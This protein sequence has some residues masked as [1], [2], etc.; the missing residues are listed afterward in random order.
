M[1]DH[2]TVISNL[3][4]E[5]ISKYISAR[6]PKIPFYSSVKA[7]RLHKASDFGPKY[8]QDN[9]E[10][11]VLFHSAV[12]ELLIGSKECSVHLEVGPHS[13]LG[14]PLRQIYSETSV[15]INYAPTLV[16][17]KDDTVSFL[18]A[19][20]QLHSLGVPI[21][22]PLATENTQVLTDLPTY[23]WHYEKS[24]WAESRI[25]KNW[26]FRKHLPHDL[27][28]LRII[29]GSDI[30]PTWRNEL[31]LVNIPWLKD[32]CVGNDIVLPGA[33]Y[34]AMAGEAVFQI[35]DIR[36]YTV[37]DVELGKAMLLYNN[38]PIEIITTLRPQRLTTT[39]DSDWYEFL[40]VSYDGSAWAKHCSG[41]VRS[42]QASAYPPRRTQS[43]DRPV[44]SSR[45]YNAMAR[46]GLNYGPRFIGLENIKAS[47]LDKVAAA[48]VINRQEVSES[49]YMLHPTTL[50]L[51]FQSLTVAEYQGVYRTFRT[52]FL[53][54]FIEELYISD[55]TGKEIQIN[56]AA[57]GKN[58]TVEGSSYGISEG[59]MIFY[60]KGFRGKAMEDLGIEKPA[61]LKSLLLQWKP[62]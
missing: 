13:A 15:A 27:L 8:W 19:V 52:V 53:P 40:V 18:E 56:T 46:A 50:D 45:W 49:P 59:E 14:G 48:D 25:M 51:V 47:V 41:L 9:L 37:R 43:L 30:T 31:R 6:A 60:L 1:L 24:Y 16:R 62:H 54:T 20:G 4:C 34:V 5:L 35:T 10:N 42:G 55:A 36:K 33:C 58:S 38:R 44:S 12:R 17:G 26:R 3:Y 23:P 39:L 22:Y 32:H 21:S 7:K 11:P 28:G 29:E 61:E 57:L 2:M